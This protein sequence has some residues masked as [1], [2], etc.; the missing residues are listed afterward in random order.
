MTAGGAVAPRTLYYDAGNRSATDIASRG[1]VDDPSNLD[2]A[3]EIRGV[4]M[5]ERCPL[6]FS[7]HLVRV[8][9]AIVADELGMGSELGDDTE[10]RLTYYVIPAGL[11]TERLASVRELSDDEVRAQDIERATAIAQRYGSRSTSGTYRLRSFAARV[12]PAGP[13]ATSRIAYTA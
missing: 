7:T 5:S 11:A 3:A 4:W 6:K 8:E 1:F 2:V 13:C 9:L 12:V 10:A